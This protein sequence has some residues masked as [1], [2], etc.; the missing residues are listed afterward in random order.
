MPNCE[1]QPEKLAKWIFPGMLIN[2]VLDV[3]Q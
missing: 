3:F 1:L 2:W